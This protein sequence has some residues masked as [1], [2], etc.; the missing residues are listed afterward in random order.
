VCGISANIAPAAFQPVVTANQTV[1]D[2]MIMPGATLTLNAGVTLT[3][4]GNYSNFG[5]LVASPTSTLL[6]NNP[7]VG[8]AL[9]GAMTAPNTFG[10]LTI[11]KT[12]GTVTLNADL[13]IGGTFTT[14]NNTSIFNTTGR[15]IKLAGNFLNSAAGTTFTNPGTTGTLEFNGTAAQNYSPG[16]NLTLNNVRMNH[17]GS[18]VTLVGNNMILGTSGVLTLTNGKI[19]TNAFEVTQNNT[20]PTSVTAGNTGSFVQGNLRRF[21]NGSTGAYDFPV[22]HAV[23][24]YQRANVTFI[25][26]T[27]IPNLLANFNTYAALPNGPISNECP[28][29][30]YNLLSVLDNGYWTITA[31]ANPTS[32]NYN[33]TLY[34]TNYT[35]SGA[36]WTVVKSAT[37]PPTTA[38]WVLSGACVPASTMPQTMRNGMNGF[39]SFGVGVSNNPLPVELLYFAGHAEGKV[40]MLEWTTASEINNDYFTLEHSADGIE[41]EHVAT[42]NGAGNSVVTLNYK[43]EDRHPF[44]G[45]TFYRLKQTDYDGLFSYSDVIVI[46]NIFDEMTLENLHPNPTTGTTEFDFYSSQSTF[47]EITIEDVYGRAM[48]KEMIP[49]ERG[50]NHFSANLSGYSPGIYQ[51]RIVGL[52]SGFSLVR[53]IVRN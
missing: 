18:G 15:Y 47:I 33:M 27:S 39:S 48:K 44:S 36:G 4:C 19:I 7:S 24:G 51:L 32:G 52:E 35:P 2:L 5:T 8:Q 22:G 50:G 37:A 11:T 43:T 53:K 40:N 12:G 23:K 30:N 28:N 21:L 38:S 26:A 1:K 14:S 46:K 9:N 25:T 45:K 49:V 6:F 17:S 42:L 34:N 16:G 10:N 41:F 29:N 3:V 20:A 13:D 31:S